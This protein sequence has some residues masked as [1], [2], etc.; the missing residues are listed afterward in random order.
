MK[1]FQ[2]KRKWLASLYNITKVTRKDLT[3][4]ETHSGTAIIVMFIIALSFMG[5]ALS[6][7]FVPALPAISIFF[8]DKAD[9]L[10]I[11]IS[12][13]LFGFACSQFFCGTLSDAIGR[14]RVMLPGLVVACLASF[15]CWHAPSLTALIAGRFIQGLGIGAVTVNARAVTRDV[16]DG[17]NS[18]RIFSAISLM[19]SV[20]PCLAPILGSYLQYHYGWQSIFEVMT[21]ALLLMSLAM[22]AFFPET[23]VTSSSKRFNLRVI[24]VNTSALTRMPVFICNALLSGCV[25]ASIMVYY[26]VSPYYFLHVLNISSI[27]YAWLSS[28]LIFCLILG[29][30]INIILLSWIAPPQIVKVGVAIFV[31]GALMLVISYILP[32]YFQLSEIYMLFIGII[33]VFSGGGLIFGNVLA[34][35]LSDCRHIAGSACSLYGTVQILMATL[36]SYLASYLPDG[37]G[38][39]LVA[40]IACLALAMV[41]ILYVLVRCKKLSK[42]Q[43]V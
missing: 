42:Y 28:G 19:K 35:A 18:A 27:Q 39:S 9:V 29:R 40:T 11:L 12:S 23:V 38:L 20:A 8:H 17:E 22:F 30:V 13:Y 15:M 37:R 7:M 33:V 10:K 31:L 24:L 41:A 26:T 4:T 16:F 5:I 25:L 6:D 43:T 14:R 2:L 32:V 36:F 3:S 21:L 34:I 1:F